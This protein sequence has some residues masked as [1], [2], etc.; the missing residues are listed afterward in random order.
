MDVRVSRT[1]GVERPLSSA[2]TSS[3][4]QSASW[5]LELNGKLV[6]CTTDAERS[7][8]GGSGQG[9]SRTFRIGVMRA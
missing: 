2:R 9:V 6:W 5:M 7:A 3:P 8:A 4:A 1:L